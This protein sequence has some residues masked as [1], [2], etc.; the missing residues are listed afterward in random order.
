[1]ERVE[2]TFI[3]HFANSNRGK[4]MNI[5]RPKPKRERHRIT[6]S[7]GKNQ[8]L[9]LIQTYYSFITETNFLCL[10]LSPMPFSGKIF[11]VSLLD[12]HW[13]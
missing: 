6:F 5:L 10:F 7:M 9:S 2:K 8:D 13:L 3:K 12:A 1:M 4:G 11:Q